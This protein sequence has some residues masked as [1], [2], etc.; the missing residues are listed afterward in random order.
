M[1]NSKSGSTNVQ[2][3]TIRYLTVVTL[4]ILS[5]IVT[6][7]LLYSS[8]LDNTGTFM[9]F[10]QANLSTLYNVFLEFDPHIQ[11]GPMA[12][13]CAWRCLLSLQYLT[14]ARGGRQGDVKNTIIKRFFSNSFN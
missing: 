14:R 6:A 11:G 7:Q 12:L 4:V 9:S 13:Q 10:R 5:T 8:D 2:V 3:I 1:T